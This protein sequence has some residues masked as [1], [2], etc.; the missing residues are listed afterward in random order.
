MYK[1]ITA[2]A[3][4]A[5]S[6]S[7]FKTHLNMEGYDDED[8]YLT[9]LLNSSIRYVEKYLKRPLVTQTV[10]VKVY[11]K[12][13][14][15]RYNGVFGERGVY[16]PSPVS[17]IVSVKS[18]DDTVVTT[19]TL[20]DFEVDTYTF[21]NVL[22]P[23]FEKE[24]TEA[25]YFLI[26]LIVGEADTAI[27]PDIQLGILILAADAYENRVMQVRDRDSNVKMFLKQYRISEFIDY[28]NTSELTDLQV[29]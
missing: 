10:E 28:T 23:V 3:S 26:Q 2:P 11:Y 16:V 21:P 5:V 8:A 1:V 4:L 12:G 7:T 9:L 24:W 20:T 22:K 27:E 6:L 17:S 14:K 25:D 19:E 18:Y 29:R 13:Y 15:N